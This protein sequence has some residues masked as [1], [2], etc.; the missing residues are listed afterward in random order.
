M[1]TQTQTAPAPSLETLA[2]LIASALNT[3]KSEGFG[4]WL[5]DETDEYRQPTQRTATLLHPSG[6]RLFLHADPRRGRLTVSVGW[7]WANGRQYYPGDY[8]TREQHQ[9][10]VSS[11][12]IS[13][14]KDA[15]QIARDIARRLMPGYLT[16]WVIAVN[17]LEESNKASKRAADAVLALETV[18]GIPSKK[19]GYAGAPPRRVV[20]AHS[21]DFTVRDG[22]SVKVESYCLTLEQALQLAAVVAGWP[23]EG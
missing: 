22:G 17:G 23:K 6:R 18:L 19:P 7:L 2:P 20:S 14:T 8:L 15:A 21:V 9:S 3:Y 13:V 12:S 11:I 4:G 10:I 16:L 5:V 1:T